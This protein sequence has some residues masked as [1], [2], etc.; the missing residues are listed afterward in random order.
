MRFLALAV[1]NQGES[2][3]REGRLSERV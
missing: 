1:F 3:S 2:Q